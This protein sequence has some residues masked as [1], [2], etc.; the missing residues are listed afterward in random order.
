MNFKDTIGVYDNVLSKTN[1]KRYIKRIEQAIVEGHAIEGQSSSGMNDNIKNST[2]FNFLNFANNKDVK[3]VELISET[4]NYNLTNNY[5]NKFPFNNEFEH[6]SVIAGKSNY[7][8]FNIQKYDK[9]KGHYNGWHVEKDCLETS[10]RAF[11]FIL[12]L[13]D[14][15]QG[16]ETEFL[17]DDN[18]DY[19]KVKPKTGRLIIHPASWPYIHRGATPTSNDKYIV[20]TW[21][22]FNS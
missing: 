18:G 22:N 11:V 4:F 20:T 12:Y 1:C 17:F 15:E 13:N 5:L 8:A 14:V 9:N 7:P 19:F 10:N 2:D 3:L 16:G 6:N 21:L